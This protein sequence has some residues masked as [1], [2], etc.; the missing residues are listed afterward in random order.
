M[1]FSTAAGLDAG[2]VK[3]LQG[4]LTDQGEFQ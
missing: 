3:P 2:M 1:G 4:G